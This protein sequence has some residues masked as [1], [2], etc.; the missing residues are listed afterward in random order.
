MSTMGEG[1]ACA[2]LAGFARSAAAAFRVAM[3]AL[4]ALVA[5]LACAD[6][7][8][9]DAVDGETNGPVIRWHPLAQPVAAEPTKVGAALPRLD[10]VTVEACELVTMADAPGA[11]PTSIQIGIPTPSRR[12]DRR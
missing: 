9:K 5:A 7:T 12:A 11:T 4:A 8:V 10:E 3:S 2:S 6:P 1:M